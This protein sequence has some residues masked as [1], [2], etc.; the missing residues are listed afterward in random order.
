V[1]FKAGAR[2]NVDMDSGANVALDERTALAAAA[3]RALLVAGMK[4]V[5]AE[6]CTGGGVAAAL[7]DVAGSSQ[8]F[9]RGYVTYSNAAKVDDLGVDPAAL[10][11]HGAVSVEVARQMAEGA[12]RRSGADVA[13]ALTGI[14]GPDGGSI[15]KP[16]GLV[17]LACG[18][19]GG[20]VQVSRELYAGDRAAVR[21]QAVAEALRRLAGLAAQSG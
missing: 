15:E 8:W 1:A 14:A 11:R 5:T 17:Y 12:L 18:R 21:E 16:V 20:T 13:V 6:S 19:R 4:A 10:E 2:F 9:E 3:G 7:T